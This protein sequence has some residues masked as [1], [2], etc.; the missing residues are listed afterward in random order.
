MANLDLEV[1]PF[2][3][4]VFSLFDSDNSGEIN[5]RECVLSL[6]SYCSLSDDDLI[7]FAFELYDQDGSHVMERKEV[8]RIFLDVYGLQINTNPYAKA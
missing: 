3:K 2:T 8:E 4:R 5:F 7:V 1:T 6:W